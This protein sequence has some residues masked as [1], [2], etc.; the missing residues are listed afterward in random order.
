MEIAIYKSSIELDKLF[1]SIEYSKD[2]IELSNQSTGSR[3]QLSNGLVTFLK[4]KTGINKLSK[5]FYDHNNLITFVH[6]CICA[7]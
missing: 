4:Y 6:D 2:W 5:K 1:N 3:R 7:T